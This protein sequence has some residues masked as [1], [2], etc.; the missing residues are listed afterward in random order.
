[1]K[2]LKWIL[3]IAVLAIIV[4]CSDDTPEEPDV[5]VV[6]PAQRTIIAYM[7][8]N[9]VGNSLPQFL[10]LDIKEMAKGSDKLPA[11]VN[12]VV[13]AN[14]RARSPTLLNFP[15]VKAQKYANGNQTSLPPTLTAC[16]PS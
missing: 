10:N 12:L 6:V 11:D 13:F 5:P 2:K 4:S 8:G 15:E 16:C 7:D 9:Q 3:F 1:M 14:I